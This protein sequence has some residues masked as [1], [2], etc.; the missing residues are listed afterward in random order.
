MAHG[1]VPSTVAMILG[2]GPV[3]DPRTARADIDPYR[4]RARSVDDRPET[5]GYLHD[6]SDGWYV[7]RGNYLCRLVGEERTDDRWGLDPKVIGDSWF[8]DLRG[9]LLDRYWRDTRLVF[10]PLERAAL[11]L[12]VVNGPLTRGELY[13]ALVVIQQRSPGFRHTR[14]KTLSHNAHEAIGVPFYA[15]MVGIWN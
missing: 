3:R 15:Q 6:E 2:E 9:V 13:R 14:S 10:E 12:V 8:G 4:D 1:S 7:P 11:D 5:E